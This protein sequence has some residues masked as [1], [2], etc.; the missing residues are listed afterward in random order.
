[1]E[2]EGV[3][4]E[5]RAPGLGDDQP[6]EIE[7]VED[8]GDQHPLVP[9]VPA[10]DSDCFRILVLDGLEGAAEEVDHRRQIKGLRIAQPDGPHPRFTQAAPSE[11]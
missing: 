8:E 6:H 1:M 11:P 3:G 5:G 7:V 2:H 4:R 9:A 10:P